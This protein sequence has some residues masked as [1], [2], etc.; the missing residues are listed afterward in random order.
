[1]INIAINFRQI[2]HEIKNFLTKKW[3]YKKL[4]YFTYIFYKEKKFF[5][6][7]SFFF[8]F[9]III[10]LDELEVLNK[11]KKKNYLF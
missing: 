7:A 1:M 10:F 5:A 8:M 3:N 11:K 6:E 2:S 9:D 4:I